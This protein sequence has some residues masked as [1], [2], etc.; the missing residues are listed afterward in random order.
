MTL[1]V[2][3]IIFSASDGVR[4]CC[5]VVGSDK[6]INDNGRNYCSSWFSK[7]WI[8]GGFVRESKIIFRHCIGDIYSCKN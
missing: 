6:Q 2:I 4:Y 7:R 5:D 1:L 8:L 3:S